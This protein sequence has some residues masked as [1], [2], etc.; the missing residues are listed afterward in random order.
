MLNGQVRK[1]CLLVVFDSSCTGGK[2]PLGVV[3]VIQECSGAVDNHRQ[4]IFLPVP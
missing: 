3:Q 4:K 2:P 1:F